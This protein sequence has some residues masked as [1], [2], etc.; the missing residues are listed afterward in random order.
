VAV[1][2]ANLQF[3][4]EFD[5]GDPDI[6][7]TASAS[8]EVTGQGGSWDAVNWDEFFWGAQDINQ[9]ELPLDGS[10]VNIAL[11]FHSNTKLD[12][13]HTLQGALVDF[14]ARRRKR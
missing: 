5:Y 9:P 13:G 14:T 4:A 6:G 10:G 2:Y 11:S 8:V 7:P 12:F 1:L 3:A